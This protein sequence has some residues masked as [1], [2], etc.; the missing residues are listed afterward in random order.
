M[1]ARVE[2]MFKR[3][4]FQI[5]KNIAFILKNRSEIFRVIAQLVKQNANTCSIY[6]VC[7]SNLM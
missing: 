1:K 7:I 6:N 5:E 4:R 2:H 3:D